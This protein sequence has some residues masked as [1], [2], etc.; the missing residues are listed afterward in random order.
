MINSIVK[1]P[2][3][4]TTS[5]LIHHYYLEAMDDVQVEANPGRD[6]LDEPILLENPLRVGRDLSAA[7]GLRGAGLR[8]RSCA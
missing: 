7:G 1:S 4:L 6:V 8:S 5:S 2:P 3:S